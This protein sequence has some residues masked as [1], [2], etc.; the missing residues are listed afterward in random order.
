MT[1]VVWMTL[2]IPGPSGLP[3]ALGVRNATTETFLSSL[4]GIL[5][6]ILR[7]APF[8]SNPIRLLGDI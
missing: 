8:Q 3:L 6:S 4:L 2:S 7:G 1:A 5:I